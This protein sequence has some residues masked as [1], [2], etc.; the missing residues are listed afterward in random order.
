[1]KYYRIS[2]PASYAQFKVK[3]TNVTGD[4]EL[5]VRK[6]SSPASQFDYDAASK[7]VGK[8]PES[9]TLA[10]GDKALW[11]IG[12]YGS[13]TSNY[14]IRAELSADQTVTLTSGKAVA[15]SVALG[16]WKYYRISTPADAAQLK[17]TL[18][19]LSADVDLYLRKASRP[20]QLEYNKRS[21]KVGTLS[22]AITLRNPGENVWY[23]GIYGSSKG[24][25]TVKAVLT[26]PL[27]G[28]QPLEE[29]TSDR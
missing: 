5:L 22:E 9:L 17:V 4:P 28:E 18:T 12:V 13:K 21:I 1:M 26:M 25:Y 7:H 20:Q 8:Q 2:A 15:S 3:L 11:Y 16:D 29:E 27:S 6:N 14:T 19:K 23:I 10:N 24:S